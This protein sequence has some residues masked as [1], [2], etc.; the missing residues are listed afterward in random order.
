MNSRSGARKRAQMALL[1][2]TSNFDCARLACT[3]AGFNYFPTADPT[4]E[5]IDSKFHRGHCGGHSP[6]LCHRGGNSHGTSPYANY[7]VVAVLGRKPATVQ[8]RSELR[9]LRVVRVV[10][11]I[12]SSKR[13]YASHQ[14]YAP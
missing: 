13:S 8:A 4:V 6:L 11:L 1:A 3:V 12:S 10:L 7:S 9:T 5:K 2:R 14:S